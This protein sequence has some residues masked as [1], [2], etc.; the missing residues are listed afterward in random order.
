MGGRPNI[1]K[2]EMC[3]EGLFRKLGLVWRE[4]AGSPFPC[5]DMLNPS[6]SKKRKKNQ[7]K[8]QKSKSNEPKK[9]K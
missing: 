2:Y 6:P 3:P 9:Y 5:I 1:H 4:E 7:V 8:L